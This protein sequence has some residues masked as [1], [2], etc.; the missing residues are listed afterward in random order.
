MLP[1]SCPSR[2]FHN[3]DITRWSPSEGR[4]PINPTDQMS[5]NTDSSGA[6]VLTL[7][8]SQAG[9][10]V[11]VLCDAFFAYPAF[12][13]VIGPA[14]D[15]YGSRLREM[16]EF[17]VTAR[18]LK[19]DLVLGV[20][21]E[22]GEIGGVAT[23][24]L[25]VGGDAPQELLERRDALWQHLGEEALARY[26]AMGDAF[27]DFVMDFPHFHLNLIGVRREL[28]GRGLGRLLLDGVHDGSARDEAS[29]GVTL[30]TE[31]PAN[32]S[33][34]ERFG[35]ETIRHVRVSDQ[36][37]TWYMFRADDTVQGDMRP[38]GS[39]WSLR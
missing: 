15:A 12:T 30:N 36:L 35:Y 4:D 18:F 13:Y 34:Y 16:M 20:A 9:E 31:D 1:A 2:F 29:R 39:A 28:A 7:T 37:E 33:L 11:E 17:F 5:Q 19:N 6:K 8:P 22:E 14:G 38:V 3:P 27:E 32:V 26:A 23:I 21:T 24:T 25:P 10:A